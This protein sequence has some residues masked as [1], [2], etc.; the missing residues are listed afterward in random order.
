M[1]QQIITHQITNHSNHTQNL[2]GDF[3]IDIALVERQNEHNTTPPQAEDIEWR[4]FTNNLH[5]TYVPTNNLYSRQGGP[6]YNQISLIDGYYINTP[7][8]SLYTSTINNDHNLNSYHSPVTLHIPSNTLLTRG[9][10]PTINIPPRMLN[11]IP[12]ANI[13]KT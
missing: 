5:L 9:P 1:I 13:K 10:S 12:Y 2:C 8:N 7:N 4:A 3:N 6:N 11:P